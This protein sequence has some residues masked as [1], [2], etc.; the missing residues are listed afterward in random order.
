MPQRRFKWLWCCPLQDFIAIFDNG[1][2]ADL[3]DVKNWATLAH[4]PAVKGQS[5]PC[6]TSYPLKGGHTKRSLR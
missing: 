3:L 1:A 2:G 4:H 5:K 6:T